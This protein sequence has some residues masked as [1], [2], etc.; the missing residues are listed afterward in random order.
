MRFQYPFLPSFSFSQI[1]I[2]SSVSSLAPA[3]PATEMSGSEVKCQTKPEIRRPDRCLPLKR[4]RRS[5]EEE[6]GGQERRDDHKRAKSGELLD[7]ATDPL[8]SAVCDVLDPCD[9]ECS[10]CMR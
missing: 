10:L 6:D 5:T 3:T 7:V 2:P 8:S 1:F 4:K 9:L